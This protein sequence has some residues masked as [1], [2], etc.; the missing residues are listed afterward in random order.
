MRFSVNE[1][2]FEVRDGETIPLGSSGFYDFD[3]SREELLYGLGTTYGRLTGSY[4]QGTTRLGFVFMKWH[5]DPES[6]E[7][8]QR[9]EVEV[10]LRG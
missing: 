4:M 7:Y 3:G 1:T 2:W 6:G 5:K 10:I 8:L 9:T